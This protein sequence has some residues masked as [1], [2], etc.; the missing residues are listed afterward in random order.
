MKGIILAGGSGSRL[1][2]LTKVVSKQLMPVFNKPMI[3]YPL[4]TLI[5]LGINDIL[6]IS[7]PINITHFKKLLNNG[8]Q[9]GI[10]IKYCVQKKPNGLA[11][12]YVLAEDFLKR[13]N[14]V[15]IL[16]DNIFYSSNI[17]DDLSKKI[18]S[19]SKVFLYKVKDPNRYGVAKIDQKRKKIVKI[20][21]KPK[22]FLSSYAITGLYF[23][24]KHAV[25]YAK[26]LKPSKRGELEITDL[27]QIYLNKK[28]LTYTILESGSAWLDTG[29]HES[30]IEA[31]QFIQTL[32]H[33]QNL[34]IGSP[35][36]SSLKQGFLKKS[37]LKKN[38]SNFKKNQYFKTILNQI[39]TL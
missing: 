6:L 31:S 30:L 11:E 16:G 8:S 9:F 13:S 15:L 24:D 4:S 23:Y 29:T 38:F 19:G 37:N 26:N 32:E 10:K 22:K 17:N 36:I 2:P 18:F 25:E 1:W 35:E 28:K 33:R 5:D 34:L 20:K 12:A 14:S 39:E 7:D 3:Y 27:N 21:E